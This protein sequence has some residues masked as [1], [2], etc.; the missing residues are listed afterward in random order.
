MVMPLCGTFDYAFV[1]PDTEA[2]RESGIRTLAEP[3]E[4]VPPRARAWLW[5]IWSQVPGLDGY[6]SLRDDRLVGLAPTLRISGSRLI[7]T[8]AHRHRAQIRSATLR[9][10]QSV[11][12]SMQ[13]GDVLTLVRTQTAG[14]GLSLLRAGHLVV[15]AGAVSSTPLGNGVDVRTGGTDFME[16]FKSDGPVDA[17][18]DVTVSGE[19]VRLRDRESAVRGDYTVTV[20]RSFR[21]GFPGTAE[22]IA[23]SR[24]GLSPHAAVVLSAERLAGPNAGLAMEDWG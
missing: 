13:P 12:D 24:E 20:V 4:A 6:D 10:D 1:V 14:I 7:L 17:W 22:S 21:V 16:A 5:N 8:A 9:L 2:A 18:T 23:I 19:T 11:I 15:A 3:P